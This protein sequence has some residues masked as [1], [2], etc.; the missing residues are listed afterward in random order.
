MIVEER[1]YTLKIG[2]L[3]AYRSL[4]L[5]EGYAVQKETLGNLIG[6]YFTDVGPQNQ[7]VHLWGYDSYEERERRRAALMGDP[8]WLAYIN[9]AKDFVERQESK[10]LKPLL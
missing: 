5:A 4:Y 10:I 2:A 1:T 9:K 3:P 8:Q 6:Y 7:V